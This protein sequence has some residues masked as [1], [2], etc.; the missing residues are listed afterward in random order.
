VLLTPRSLK[1]LDVSRESDYAVVRGGHEGAVTA[2][3]VGS[4]E[5]QERIFSAS[6]DNTIRQWDPYDLACIRVFEEYRSEVS[7]MTFAGLSKKLVTGHDDGSVRLW[8]LDTG[9]TVNLHEP[10]RGHGN[11]VACVCVVERNGGDE[12]LVATGGFDGRVAVWDVRKTRHSRPHLMTAWE[13]HQG[14]EILSIVAYG[15]MNGMDPAGGGGGAGRAGSVQSMI[16]AG[17][18]GVIRLWR[19]PGDL[20]GEFWGH[21]E[22]VTCMA[23][24][25]NFLFSGSEDKTIQV[26][27]ARAGVAAGSSPTPNLSRSA[28]ATPSSGGGRDG[29]TDV[30]HE[31]TVGGGGGGG[32]GGGGGGGSSSALVKTLRGHTDAVVAMQVLAMTGH[33]LSIAVNGTLLVWDASG[34]GVIIYRFEHP[35]TFRCMIVRERDNQVLIGTM[36]DNIIVHFALPEELREDL[37]LPPKP[38]NCPPTPDVPS[39]DDEQA[40]LED[41]YGDIAEQYVMLGGE[42]SAVDG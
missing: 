18:D 38:D 11:T 22:A 9:S 30:C 32:R 31:E 21:E 14:S 20:V 1:G 27:D 10:E 36:E 41:E 23:L 19:G 3:A 35:D 28:S 17:N 40:E 24:D 6:L 7:C 8:D 33:L 16:T 25:G 37:G 2:F 29:T 26:W 13:A 39:S 5:G 34:E 42:F 12:Q 4:V 15:G